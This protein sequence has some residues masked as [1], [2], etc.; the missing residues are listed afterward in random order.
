MM[1]DELGADPT[2]TDPAVADGRRKKLERVEA[3]HTEH[4]SWSSYTEGQQRSPQWR[5][6]D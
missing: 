5:Q 2:W 4:R 1:L 6:K 3:R